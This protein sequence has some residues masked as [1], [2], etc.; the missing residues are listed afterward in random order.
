MKVVYA[1]E[2]F[3]ES[4]S[5][6]VFLAGPTPRAANV[7]SWRPEAISLLEK[8]GFDGVVFVPEDSQA[9]PSFDYMHQVEWEEKGLNLADAIVFWIPRDLDT[10]PG[11][12]TNI[13]WGAWCD[14]G[15]VVL[16]APDGAPKLAYLEHYANK[17]HAPIA[18]T[19]QQT[20]IDA[21][22]LI[23]PGQ[24]RTGGEC[25]VPLWIWR[26]RPF[27]KW[28]QAQQTAGNQLEGARVLWRF[29]ADQQSSPFCWVIEPKIFIPDE[30]RR[31]TNEVIITRPDISAVLAYHRGTSM[32]DTQVV[33]VREFRSNAATADGFV[34]ELPGG[35]SEIDSSA[36]QVAADEL[37]EETGISFPSERFNA[38]PD[39]QCMATM[40]T[41]RCSLF[42]I[43]LTEQ[44]LNQFKA[45]EGKV[46]GENNIEQTY[47]EIR[48][49]NEILD[50]NDVD[51]THV[52]MILS[53][54]N[55][56]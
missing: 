18:T 35:S 11:F 26:T 49:V 16:G 43:E 55:S 25:D 39:R 15:K 7:K 22:D 44:E 47:V 41:H 54:L 42:S 46:F 3:P 34:H 5:R 13:E 14:S 21:I 32:G 48:T 40:L 10:L 28:Y 27:Q 30:G 6:S 36:L 17:Y 29:P 8:M 9:A 4:F 24:N 56:I 31:K 12:T 51:W 20:L 2:P 53:V 45:Q 37:R 19:L 1:R 23:G 50:S 52:G 33:L 38:H